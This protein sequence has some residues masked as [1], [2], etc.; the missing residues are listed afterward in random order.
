MKQVYLRLLPDAE[1]REDRI[2]H[3]LDI[4]PARNPA[5]RPRGKAKILSRQLRIAGALGAPHRIAG[6]FD[7]LAMADAGERRTSSRPNVRATR[8]AS[9]ASSWAIPSRVRAETSNTDAPR[10]SAICLAGP[11]AAPARR[12][13][14]L[15]TTMSDGRSE[16]NASTDSSSLRRSITPMRKSEFSARSSARRTPSASIVSR[17]LRRPAVSASQTA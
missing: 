10:C 8:A 13:V 14:L 6:R 16:A 4:D 5:D 7:R 2:Q 9:A 12:S 15:S 17:A 11:T 1:F 3:K